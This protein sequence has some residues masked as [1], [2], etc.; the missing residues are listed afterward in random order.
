MASKIAKHR[1]GFLRNPFLYPSH[2][3]VE[4]RNLMREMDHG[5]V[6]YEEKEGHAQHLV[7][8]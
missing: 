8:T 7:L 6:H 3:K 1:S 4:S 5:M 2:G